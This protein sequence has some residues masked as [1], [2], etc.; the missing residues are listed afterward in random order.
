MALKGVTSGFNRRTPAPRIDMEGVP[1]LKPIR[2]PSR[3]GHN[4][5]G[6]VAQSSY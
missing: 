4:V 2:V 3:F 6:E 1:S 5:G